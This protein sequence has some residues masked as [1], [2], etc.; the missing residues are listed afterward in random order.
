MYA[1]MVA[2]DADAL[3]AYAP[4]VPFAVYLIM[5]LIEG[6]NYIGYLDFG[7]R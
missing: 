1:A 4:S 3:G 7:R 2:N 6:L 5:I